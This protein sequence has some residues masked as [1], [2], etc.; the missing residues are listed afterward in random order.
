M[1]VFVFKDQLIRILGFGHLLHIFISGFSREILVLLI[2]LSSDCL[3]FQGSMTALIIAAKGGYGE[4][5]NAILDCNP[6]VNSVDKVGI[7][8][9]ELL[10]IVCQT[11]L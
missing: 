9:I 8:R 11:L 5:V 4:V 7:V 1:N 2:I 6:N 3:M 10:P